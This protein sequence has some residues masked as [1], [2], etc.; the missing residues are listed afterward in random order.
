MAYYEIAAGGVVCRGACAGGEAAEVALNYSSSV[1]RKAVVQSKEPSQ[2][3]ERKQNKESDMHKNV[4]RACNQ[5]FH[6]A[7][8]VNG[9]RGV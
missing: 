4:C 2:A 6:E 9:D 1:N 8:R 7:Q 3:L 5:N